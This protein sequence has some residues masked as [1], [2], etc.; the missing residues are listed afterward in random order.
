MKTIRD[1]KERLE[2]DEKQLELLNTIVKAED[3]LKNIEHKIAKTN[4]IIAKSNAKA[5]AKAV[6]AKTKA[7]LQNLREL[8]LQSIMVNK[9]MEKIEKD[10]EEHIKNKKPV[11]IEG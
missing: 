3:K 5:I 11:W 4:V 6:E 10:I 9:D 2:I 8:K 1:I 7:E